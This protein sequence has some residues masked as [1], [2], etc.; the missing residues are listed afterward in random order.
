MISE[1]CKKMLVKPSLS[2]KAALKQMDKIALQVLIV[3]DDEDRILGIVTDGDMR[4][5][6][7]KGLDFKTPIQDIM[8]KN[9]IV[10]SYKSN[11]EEVLQSMKKYEVRHIPVVDEKNKIIEFFLWKDFLKNG[12]D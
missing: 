6:I 4:R 8:T 3:V 5:A 1:Q 7:I 9:P 12:N 10:I 11:K 2:L